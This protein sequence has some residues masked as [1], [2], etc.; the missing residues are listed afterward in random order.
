MIGIGIWWNMIWISNFEYH[1]YM[2]N[3]VVYMCIS[4]PCY[5]AQ[6]CIIKISTIDSDREISIYVN[7][8][9]ISHNR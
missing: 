9:S 1:Y 4:V 5:L 2:T 6:V 3:P 7:L 8:I